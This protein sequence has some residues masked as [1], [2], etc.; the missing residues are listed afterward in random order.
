MSAAARAVARD[1][2][3]QG[4]ALSGTV[5]N[6]I[7]LKAAAAGLGAEFKPALE[8]LQKMERSSAS[9]K[10][11]A[12]ALFSGSEQA[13]S[14]YYSKLDA[15][16][17]KSAG[18]IREVRD[19]Q[20]RFNAEIKARSEGGV[21][22]GDKQL[23]T[24]AR[25]ASEQRIQ[26]LQ[27]E[28][29]EQASLIKQDAVAAAL[30]DANAARQVASAQKIIDAQNGLS[31]SYR[32]QLTLLRELRDAGQLTPAQFK[33]AGSELVAQQPGFKARQAEQLAA[34]ALTKK[35][36]DEQAVLIRK[37]ADESEAAAAK[38]VAAAR[39][40][41]DSQNGL[42][43]SYRE[44][45]RLLRELRDTGRISPEQFRAAGAKLVTQQP[46]LQVNQPLVSRIQQDTQ[47]VSA[48]GKALV[49]VGGATKIT[50]YELQ[51]LNY[52]VSDVVA[53]L[54]SGISPMT[55]LLQQGGQVRDVFGSF[56]AVFSKIGS[57][58]T[59][60]RVGV[61]AVVGVAAAIAFA[62]KNT[63]HWQ[64]TLSDLQAS[65][66]GTGRGGSFSNSQLTALIEQIALA[67]GVTR[68]AAAKTV[69]ELAR[70]SQIS[71]QLFGNLGRIAADY[72][73][74]TGTDVPTAAKTLAQAFSEPEKG[75]KT[76]ES[77]LGTLSS[78]TLLTV[79]RLAQQGDL[80]GAQ[81]ALYAGLEQ[82]VKGLATNGITPLQN[83]TNEFGNA[84]DRL[85]GRLRESDGLQSV[86]AGLASLLVGM[87]R[88]IDRGPEVTRALRFVPG[89]T[90]LLAN[91]ATP[92]LTP[93]AQRRVEGKVTTL[94]G[95]TGGADN[96][97]ASEE[98]IKRALELGSAYQST[99]GKID[100]LVLKQKALRDSLNLATTSYGANSEQA[101]RL[102]SAVAGIGEQIESL[103]KKGAKKDN[104]PEQVRQQ[105]LAADLK[106]L[107][108]AFA[109]ERDTITFHTQRVA[110][111]YALGTVSLKEANDARVAEIQQGTTREVDTLL[112]EIA[113]LK[114][115]LDNPLVK[116]NPS[117]QIK[118]NGQIAEAVEKTTQVAVKGERAVV[119]ANIAAAQSYKQ[120]ADQVNGYR[121]SVLQLQGDEAGAAAL[122][123]KQQLVSARDLQKQSQNAPNPADRI[124]D[125]EIQDYERALRAQAAVT[126]AKRQT[127]F[128]NE[129]LA[130]TEERIALAAQKGAIGE[131]EALQQQG[132][133]RQR[134]IGALELQLAAME[135]IKGTSNDPQLILDIERTRLEL[136]K[137]K[138]T[139]DPLKEKFDNLFK[140]SGESFF[141]DLL[142]GKG[143]KGAL[144]SFGR[145]L[146]GEL[147]RMVSKDLSRQIFGEGGI[148]GG[149]GKALG[150][151]F[152]TGIPSTTPTGIV[153][154]SIG[155]A[156]LGGDA[157]AA[158][159][160][161][162]AASTIAAAQASSAAA[163]AAANTAAEAATA[164][165][166]VTAIGASTTAI[167]A[168]I[169]SQALAGG[170]SGL[171][172][173]GGFGTG[174]GFGNLDL[175][176][177]L[178]QGGIAGRDGKPT[179]YHSGGIA[180]LAPDE[181]PAILRR[182]EEVLT[183]GNP[184]HRNNGGRGGGTTV[185]AP[186]T[187][188]VQG[189]VDKRTADQIGATTARE[190]RER[191]ARS[192]N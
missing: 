109:D 9:A 53:S 3:K 88:I 170:A 126:E 91:I 97:K 2:D 77:A 184:R 57:L 185:H 38:Q 181:V 92:F 133:A 64:R 128:I 48:F 166:I 127:G 30:A 141:R 163:I 137:L 144:Q 147:D 120:L 154:G 50:R 43:A 8:A 70:V 79:Q 108:S 111:L 40:I 37:T 67:P 63:E 143:I 171:S 18:A 98:A 146:T 129:R 134:V 162:L 12:I 131:L 84:W 73:R 114:K 75:A 132:E 90:G 5:A 140:D 142:G 139:L 155:I 179:R 81:R 130:I 174:A 168:A 87:Q 112:K 169:S 46:A 52:T 6:A 15:L 121:S 178:H 66:A 62:A 100:E 35:A 135:A 145:T 39:R 80:V 101:K 119:L 159:A 17:A 44:E 153:P 72:A 60:I 82:S 55:I 138:A 27:R 42:N 29:V 10:K 190:L 36:V 61:G 94:P 95:A 76:L 19:A 14:A 24:A 68:E 148:L 160:Q 149:A 186:I 177:F 167:V 156:G 191:L 32:T 102:R 65:L 172:G 23:L 45:L 96:A 180:G 151:I 136:D 192:T 85:M 59:P 103:R 106:A 125:Q 78:T 58:F 54:A 99:A 188:M 157:A 86:N 89:P 34:A 116:A 117:E 51:T 150:D 56:G 165:A 41:V 13:A 26:Q 16:T 187:V 22:P 122:R 176:L 104:E 175:G 21:S 189:S 71:G 69:T 4:A 183:A 123:I 107:Q 33:S 25:S 31:A 158:S 124:S 1:I 164:T 118:I 110:A 113:R 11:E 49:G 105:Q 83:A 20:A 7:A 161:A 182:G 47:G 93:G 74:V 173:L 152:K 28:F 115:E